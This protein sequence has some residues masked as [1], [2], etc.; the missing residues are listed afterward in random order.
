MAS[1]KD[2]C[3]FLDFVLEEVTFQEYGR[4][5]CVNFDC[6]TYRHCFKE[7]TH[8]LRTRLD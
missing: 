5:Y 7:L 3:K 4:N 8:F 6:K 2:I 1:L